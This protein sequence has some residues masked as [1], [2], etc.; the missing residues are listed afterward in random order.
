MGLYAPFPKTTSAYHKDV[1]LNEYFGEAPRGFKSSMAGW[2]IFRM[3][4]TGNNWIIQFPNGDD[5][6]KYIWDNVES[7]TYRELGT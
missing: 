6:P 2:Q 1:G 4:K 7:Y 5:S 3:T